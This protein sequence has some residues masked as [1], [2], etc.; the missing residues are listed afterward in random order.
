MRRAWKKGAERGPVPGVSA[1][2]IQ[3]CERAGFEGG[4]ALAQFGA[5]Q[6]REQGLGVH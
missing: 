1:E 2:Q 3:L 6:C 5:V 4:V